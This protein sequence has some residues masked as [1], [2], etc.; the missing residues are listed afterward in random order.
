MDLCKHPATLRVM[1]TLDAVITKEVKEHM[2]ISSLRVR[3]NNVARLVIENVDILDIG[4]LKSKLPRSSEVFI[5]S[6]L[7]S[8]NQE[9]VSS[10][11]EIYYS[12]K[13]W[14]LIS[15]FIILSCAALFLVYISTA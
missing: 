15:T 9:R 7:N 2:K 5:R 10:R 12:I 8:K 3:Q 11:I 1:R 13:S 4:K 14:D 6:S